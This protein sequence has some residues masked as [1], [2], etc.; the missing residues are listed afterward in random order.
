MELVST[1][2]EGL[3]IK[4]PYDISILKTASGF[5]FAI[6]CFQLCLTKLDASLREALRTDV[7]S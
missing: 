2:W 4:Q 5:N 6:V 7:G 3:T 1:I